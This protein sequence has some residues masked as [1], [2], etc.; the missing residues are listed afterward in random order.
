MAQMFSEQ[1]DVAVE[2]YA[3]PSMEAEYSSN[4]AFGSNLS[5]EN[6]RRASRAPFA[7]DGRMGPTGIAGST[8]RINASTIPAKHTIQSLIV[9]VL[10]VF[11]VSVSVPEPKRRSKHRRHHGDQGIGETG[12]DSTTGLVSAGVPNNSN[13]S[14]APHDHAHKH[15]STSAVKDPNATGEVRYFILMENLLMSSRTQIQRAFDLKGSQQR[16]FANESPRSTFMDENMINRNRA[17]F[18]LYV[19]EDDSSWLK[20]VFQRDTELLAQSNVMDYSLI[21]GM[22]RNVDEERY[23]V[24]AEEVASSKAM[25]MRPTLTVRPRHDVE[26]DRER[27]ARQSERQQ[28]QQWVQ[29]LLTS[30]KKEGAQPTATTT[31]VTDSLSA[32][33]VN[34]ANPSAPA[35]PRS[36]RSSSQAATVSPTLSMAKSV[37]DHTLGIQSTS[38]AFSGQGTSTLLKPVGG[39][40]AASPTAA[41]TQQKTAAAGRIRSESRSP[42]RRQQFRSVATSLL[43]TA[44]AAASGKAPTANAASPALTSATLAASQQQQQANIPP[45]QFVD[46]LPGHALLHLGII[47]YLHPFDFPKMVENTLKTIFE[48]LRQSNVQLEMDYRNPTIIESFDYKARFERF[49][50]Q[51][52]C[53]VPGK[54]SMMRKNYEGLIR[55]QRQMVEHRRM[56][57]QMQQREREVAAATAAAALLAGKH[58]MSSSVLN[59]NGSMRG[60]SEATRT[61]GPSAGQSSQNFNTVHNS[62]STHTASSAQI[63]EEPAQRA[64][65]EA[66]ADEEEV[67]NNLRPTIEESLPEV[68]LPET[69][70]DID[71]TDI[72][73][74]EAAEA[75]ENKVSAEDE[76]IVRNEGFE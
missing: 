71:P 56:V 51:Y 58:Q 65:P 37:D 32:E 45:V 1:Q 13:L 17:G 54:M 11:S 49:M 69:R 41:S 28:R 74:T 62:C 31:F 73:T 59:S 23:F 46:D 76:E 2:H 61:R 27:K 26:V 40:A 57:L 16:R 50:G 72:K 8:E 21:A 52:F 75:P 55:R 4:A 60:A 47:D 63:A 35:A 53:C 67:H 22:E 66:I 3:W 36:E 34:A 5:N 18:F 70:V 7:T 6:G 30:T 12:M 64:T 33:A 14:A 68:D 38:S 44:A 24:P 42:S 19:T 20:T 9:K 15:H 25:G 48:R 43:L 10:G 29:Q 39:S